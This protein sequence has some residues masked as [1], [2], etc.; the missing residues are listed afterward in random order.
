MHSV[1][2][3]CIVYTYNMWYVRLSNIYILT[4]GSHRIY[5]V[6][7]KHLSPNCKDH[8]K[9][10]LVCK[11]ST[12]H[13]E[14]M[15]KCAMQYPLARPV[16]YWNSLRI[17]SSLSSIER[18]MKPPVFYIV[19]SIGDLS[20]LKRTPCLPQRIV[21]VPA[22]EDQCRPKPLKV[23]ARDTPRRS[24]ESSSV[25]SEPGESWGNAVGMTK[26]WV[27]DGYMMGIWWVYD[28]YMMGIWWVERGMVISCDFSISWDI[29]TGSKWNC[30]LKWIQPAK[31]RLVKSP[32]VP[33][34]NAVNS[35]LLWW[36]PYFQW[37]NFHVGKLW[38][39]PLV[40]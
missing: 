23:T 40:N 31:R 24:C 12:K 15:S 35:R 39:Y 17:Q 38:L 7:T 28:G 6:L 20:F 18:N 2:M 5:T 22:V 34:W 29:H 3:L 21:V 4:L 36:D 14:D 27:H 16:L 8:Q 19:S 10:C 37:W 33:W 1:C 13:S 26:W 9:S 30:I 11:Q 32:W 25:S